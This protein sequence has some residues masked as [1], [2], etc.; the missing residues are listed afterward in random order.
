[1]DVGF[2]TWQDAFHS[3][4]VRKRSRRQKNKLMWTSGVSLNAVLRSVS[5]CCRVCCN[6]NV[7]LKRSKSFSHCFKSLQSFFVHRTS[8]EAFV[9]NCVAAISTEAAGIVL[10]IKKT[11]RGKKMAPNS[12]SGIRQVSGSPESQ[13][14][15][16][17]CYLHSWCAVKLVCPDKVDA[18]AFSLAASVKISGCKSRFSWWIWADEVFLVVF[19]YI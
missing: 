5:A 15:M 2:K 19:F 9:L 6:N 7:T 8:F 14:Y 18:N 4:A 11:T 12:S 3:W 13:I 10:N 17:R 16:R 1:M